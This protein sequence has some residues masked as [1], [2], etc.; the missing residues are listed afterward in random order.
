MSATATTYFDFA[1]DRPQPD[2]SPITIRS[3]RDMLLRRYGEA[4]PRHAEV[5]EVVTVAV[6]DAA[7]IDRDSF[8]ILTT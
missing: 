4:T 2:L 6:H 7:S 1:T 8:D 3:K 5:G